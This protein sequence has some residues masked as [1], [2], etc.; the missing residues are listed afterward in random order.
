LLWLYAQ[1]AYDSLK[2]TGIH[3]RWDI[4]CLRSPDSQ[5]VPPSTA[6]A[7][8]RGVDLRALFCASFVPHEFN[9]GWQR[10]PFRRYRVRG[11]MRRQSFHPWS[12]TRPENLVC[13]SGLNNKNVS[14]CPDGSTTGAFHKQR[15]PW[16]GRTRAV[17]DGSDTQ[18]GFA[19]ICH[20]VGR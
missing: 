15:W 8:K 14:A 12:Q 11:R 7:R 5:T 20:P 19:S 10:L 6:S 17:S 3:R 13:D 16:L 4:P 9:I 1:T 2:P 18:A